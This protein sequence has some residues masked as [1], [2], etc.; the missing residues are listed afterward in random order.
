[1]MK[2]SP[3]VLMLYCIFLTSLC[4]VTSVSAVSSEQYHLKLLAVEED[5]AGVMHGTDADVFLEVRP[6]RGRV[7]LD[8]YPATKMDTQISTRYA[9][10]IACEIARVDCSGFDFTYTIQA[11]TSIIGGP[12]AGAAVSAITTIALLDLPYSDDVA[13]T[14]TINSGGIVGPVG[15]VKQKIEAASDVGLSKVLISQGSANDSSYSNVT[16]QTSYLDL[17]QYGHDNLSIEVI[18]VTSL[19]EVVYYLTGKNITSTHSDVVKNNE[20]SLIMGQVREKLCARSMMLN[21]SYSQLPL[22]FRVPLQNALLQSENDSLNQNQTNISLAVFKTF[23]EQ[24][25]ERFNKSISAQELGNDYSAASFCFGINIELQNQLLEYENLSVDALDDGF[26]R[27]AVNVSLFGSELGN[28]TIHTISDLQ[29]KMIVEERLNDVS[30]TLSSPDK[31]VRLLAYGIERFQTAQIWQDFFM[32][33]GEKVNVDENTLILACNAKLTEALERIQY[34][35]LFLPPAMVSGIREKIGFAVTAR[36]NGLYSLCLSIASQAKADSNAI[37]TSIGL[38]HS[39]VRDFILGKQRAVE[40]IIALQS[41][42]GKFPILGYSYY[43]YAKTLSSTDPFTSLVYMEYALELSDLSL[44]FP[45][46]NG[47]VGIVKDYFIPILSTRERYLAIFG[48]G[49]GIICS[50]IVYL[51]LQFRIFRREQRERY[52]WKK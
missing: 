12:S 33:K 28:R 25:S 44:Y 21:L 22:Q 6:G 35:E 42:E 4:I 47:N 24:I 19:Q 40:Q 26:S 18:E 30:N 52:R 50:V 17:V 34:T 16:N 31:N 41:E 48:F 32:M 8:T 3:F 39:S 10:D 15:G 36:D 45:S 20:Y 11:K 14:G 43:E 23:E 9:K 7:F 29:T 46:S 5:G 49:L 13:V 2:K 1:M 27:L 37:L 38:S 51:L